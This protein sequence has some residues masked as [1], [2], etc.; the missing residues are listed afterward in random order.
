MNRRLKILKII[1]I[2]ISLS[3]ISLFAGEKECQARR[4]DKILEEKYHLEPKTPPVPKYLAPFSYNTPYGKIKT[5][6]MLREL[7]GNYCDSSSNLPLIYA[8]GYEASAILTVVGA[9]FEKTYPLKDY[10]RAYEDYINL[11]N[12]VGYKIN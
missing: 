9:G 12:T 5:N 1:I 3:P 7:A 6:E 8:S 4:A 2:I 11:L 10:K